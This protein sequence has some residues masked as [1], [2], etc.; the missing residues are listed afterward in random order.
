MV[1][2]QLLGF[3]FGGSFINSE[4][5]ND[6]MLYFDKLIHYDIREY[7]KKLHKN[8]EQYGHYEKV[9]SKRPWEYREYKATKILRRKGYLKF[10][11]FS[12]ILPRY[13][14]VINKLAKK[15]FFQAKQKQEFDVARMFRPLWRQENRDEVLLGFGREL[16]YGLI[17]SKKYGA[18]PYTDIPFYSQAFS[19]FLEY[20]ATEIKSFNIEAINYQDFIHKQRI[21]EEIV[22]LTVPSFRNLDQK[23][24]IQLKESEFYAFKNFQNKVFNLIDLIKKE[25]D[26]D[27]KKKITY[28]IET[29]INP[30][31][32]E[33]KKKNLSL[34]KD[35][36][37]RRISN[38]SITGA[39][40]TGLLLVPLPLVLFTLLPLASVQITEE[41]FHKIQKTQLKEDSFYFLWKL[42]QTNG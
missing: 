30:S 19:K 21:L 10:I 18:I 2:D 27:Y 13:G 8:M 20:L 42:R 26:D 16:A 40:L 3:Y 29:E 15:F 37:K 9:K 23:A 28:F 12:K 1:K 31:I 7:T 11:K 36:G 39:T 5:L 35:I 25:F 32:E 41:V 22:N 33:I 4:S 34:T 14:D 6:S 24:I 38:L 17:G